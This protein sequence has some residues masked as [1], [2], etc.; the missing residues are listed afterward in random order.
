MGLA[1]THGGAVLGVDATIIEVEVNVGG[2]QLQY[3]L[4]GLPDA[5]IKEGQHRIE[6]A[7]K[8]NAY[9]MPRQKVVINMAPAD[10]RKEGSAYD[11][12]LAIGILSAA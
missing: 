5:A 10:I 11:L 3:F 2:G 7:L 12:T 1:K 9:P 4:V 6:A 8:N